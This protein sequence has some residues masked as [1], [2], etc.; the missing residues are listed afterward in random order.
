MLISVSYLLPCGSITIH[1]ERKTE[2]SDAFIFAF[3]YVLTNRIVAPKLFFK[4]A[5]DKFLNSRVEMRPS[6]SE[7]FRERTRSD[8]HAPKE[9]TKRPKHKIGRRVC[10]ERVEKLFVFCCHFLI[11]TNQYESL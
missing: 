11:S 3:R 7:V 2:T 8:S 4:L 6:F 10:S 9:V 1:A 5:H